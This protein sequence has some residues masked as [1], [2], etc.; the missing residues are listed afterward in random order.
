MPLAILPVWVSLLAWK[1]HAFG[2]EIASVIHGTDYQWQQF[3]NGDIRIQ[4]ILQAV[5]IT[6]KNRDLAL[7]LRPIW[8][9]CFRER[10]PG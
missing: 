6:T 4:R 1:V 8:E 2:R 3:Y 5:T 9:S 10:F 7:V